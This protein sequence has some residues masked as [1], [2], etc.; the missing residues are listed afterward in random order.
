[1]GL[2]EHH[3]TVVFVRARQ[4]DPG[5]G[6]RGARSP[7]D[8]CYPFAEINGTLLPPGQGGGGETPVYTSLPPLVTPQ[9]CPGRDGGRYVIGGHARRGECRTEDAGRRRGHQ[10]ATALLPKGVGPL[11]G[12]PERRGLELGKG[13]ERLQPGRVGPQAREPK[14]PCARGAFDVPRGLKH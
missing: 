3:S 6:V 5:R 1:M 11:Q 12:S 14:I 9:V 7:T 4:V 2:R 13:K 10:Q 8:W